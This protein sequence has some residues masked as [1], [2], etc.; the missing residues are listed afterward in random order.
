LSCFPKRRESEGGKNGDKRIVKVKV[1][2]KKNNN[3][4]PGTGKKNVLSF[5]KNSGVIP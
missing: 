3:K 4:T 5:G 1:I 2:L